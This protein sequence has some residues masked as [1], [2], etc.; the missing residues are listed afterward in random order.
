[1]GEEKA[2]RGVHVDT[3]MSGEAQEERGTEDAAKGEGG[4]MKEC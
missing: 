3:G 2:D 1:M 4:R